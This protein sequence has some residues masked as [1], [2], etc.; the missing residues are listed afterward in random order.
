MLEQL[1][2]SIRRRA[3]ETLDPR[4]EFALRNADVMADHPV[5][6]RQNELDSLR[7][8]TQATAD[9]AHCTCPEP[10]ERDHANE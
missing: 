3:V 4:G 1:T 9:T 7:G 6:A 5:I 2:T 8:V 10:C